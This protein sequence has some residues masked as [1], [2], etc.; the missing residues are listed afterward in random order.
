MSFFT[1]Q[2]ATV[3]FSDGATPTPASITFDDVGDFSIDG[4]QEAGKSTA[5][6][7]H[8]GAF[9]SYVYGDEAHTM[10]VDHEV[11]MARAQL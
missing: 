6:I 3:T 5:T 10:E 1:K 11:Q 7:I 8:R 4:L 9:K 2:H